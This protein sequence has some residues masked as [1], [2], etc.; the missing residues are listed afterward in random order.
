MP[1]MY[2]D[3]D[4]KCPFFLSSGKRKVSCE[5]MTDDCTISLNFV[6]RE[7]KCLHCEIF[8]NEHYKNCEIYRMLEEKYED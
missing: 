7:K 5:G 2:D 6:T 3:V 8:C 4:V 1:T